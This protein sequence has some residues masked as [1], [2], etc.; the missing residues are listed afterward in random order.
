MTE[1]N[2]QK[3]NTEQKTQ[4]ANIELRAKNTQTESLFLTDKSK[5]K[6][7]NKRRIKFIFKLLNDRKFEFSIFLPTIQFSVVI[8]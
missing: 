4:E 6:Q 2:T 3:E 7:H 5:I 1:H 8:G